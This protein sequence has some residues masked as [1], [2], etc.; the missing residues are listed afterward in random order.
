MPLALSIWQ[1]ISWAE[2]QCM[3]GHKDQGEAAVE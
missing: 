3:A 2:Q 1:W